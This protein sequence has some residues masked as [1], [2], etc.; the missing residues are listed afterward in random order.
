MSEHRKWR[1]FFFSNLH[2]SW[3]TTPIT[4]ISSS[5]YRDRSPSFKLQTRA[6]QEK[7]ILHHTELN[8]ASHSNREVLLREKVFLV[9]FRGERRMIGRDGDTLV[10]KHSVCQCLNN[11]PSQQIAHTG[12]GD[13]NV[14]DLTPSHLSLSPSCAHSFADTTTP[15]FGNLHWLYFRTKGSYPA[16]VNSTSPQRRTNIATCVVGRLPGEK[17]HT[18]HYL[19]KR[20]R[21]FFSSSCGW[22]VHLNLSSLKPKA[23]S[24]DA[25]PSMT[26]FP[27]FNFYLSLSAFSFL[28]L[29]YFLPAIKQSAFML[30]K[31][32]T[33]LSL[34]GA[35]RDSSG[36]P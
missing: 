7:K 33:C 18:F 26:P 5:R 4:Q 6:A 1:R 36:Q 3:F 14:R 27:E 17:H 24:E 13:V 21:L 22:K 29:R 2:V 8:L 30:E 15:T 28:F 31:R 34:G 23:A 12:G 20:E 35:C 16:R 9:P 10:K 19:G 32:H 25:Y 11:S